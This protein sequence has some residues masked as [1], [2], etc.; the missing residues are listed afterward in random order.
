MLPGTATHASQLMEAGSAISYR[1]VDIA[2]EQAAQPDQLMLA[3]KDVSIEVRKG[4]FTSI[5]GPSG[6]GKTSLLRLCAGFQEPTSGSVLCNGEPIRGLNHEVGYIT[7]QSNLYAWMTTRE[8]VEF[9]LEVRGGLTK[10]ERRQRSDLYLSKMSLAEFAD[11][12]PH[13]LSGGMQKRA[14]IAQTLIYEPSIILMD[15][16]FAGLDSQTRMA[17][18]ADL[19][20]LWTDLR[21]TIVFVTHDLTEAITLSDEVVVMSPRPGQ[22][23]AVYTVPLPRPRD[24]YGIQADAGF[25]EAYSQLWRDFSRG[26]AESGLAPSVQTASADVPSGPAPPGPPSPAE[27]PAKASARRPARRRPTRSLGMRAAQV[28]LLVVILGFWELLSDFHILDPLIFSHPVGVIVALVR[29]LSGDHAAQGSIYP[30]IWTTFS[31]MVLGFAI[32]SALSI[33]LGVGLARNK[34]VAQT[35]EPFIFAWFGVPIITIAPLFVLLLGIGYD[36]KVGTAVIATFFGVFFQ[37]YAGVKS[38]NEEQF[39][40][41]KLMG[42]SRLDLLRKILVPGSLPFIFLGLRMGVPAAMTG[43]IVGEF[44]A[45]SQGLGSFILNASS[46]FDAP[47]TFA[48]LLLVVAIVTVSG[49]IVRIAEKSIVRW[50]QG[51]R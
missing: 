23:K 48:A 1:D 13:Q 25:S 4:S 44:I 5:I 6:C 47:D 42:A 7:Q 22:V 8:N 12:Y 50:N 19:L 26:S 14:C 16:P 27:A 32:G 43:A 28:G 46:S 3:L 36:A 37:T 10:E 45:S 17:V 21:P 11:Y 35:V 34:A 9:A 51:Q 24:V 18:E 39:L 38:L 40:L 2:Y 41:A 49:W 15:E 30:Q 20:A 31:E 33:I 29:L